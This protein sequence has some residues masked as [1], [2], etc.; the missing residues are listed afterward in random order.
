MTLRPREFVIVALRMQRSL[1]KL[2]TAY[3]YPTTSI[4]M[5]RWDSATSQPSLGLEPYQ[6]VL[7]RRRKVHPRLIV[8]HAARM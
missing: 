3:C 7:Y 4:P 1:A 5:C 2:P 6:A 8:P